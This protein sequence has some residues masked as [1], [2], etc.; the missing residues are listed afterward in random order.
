MSDMQQQQGHTR[1]L[2]N[3]AMVVLETFYSFVLKHD[4]VVRLQAK[5]FIEQETTIKINSYI[6][7]FDFYVQFTDKGLLFDLKAPEQAIDLTVSST[8]VDLIQVFIFA[9][10]RSLK[11][12][13]IE[14]DV[15][16]K[17]EFRDLLLHLSTPK[18]LS[19]WKQ[20]LSNTD[21]DD[22]GSIA[23]KKR[24]APLLEK[25]DLQRSKINT[26]QVEVKQYKNR[27]RRMQKRINF[28]FATTAVLFLALIVYNLCLI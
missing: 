28:A 12:M 16:L 5:K 20:W 7:Y 25:I 26:L 22:D 19:D 6:P 11:K 1:L 8:L 21:T 18:L 24:I 14:G 15:T 4:R 10:R 2:L 13:R 23:S 17:D 3:I 27:I 9:N